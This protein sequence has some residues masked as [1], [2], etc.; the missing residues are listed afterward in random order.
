MNAIHAV[1]RLP[2]VL[3]VIAPACTRGDDDAE[4][5]A[6]STGESDAGA[7][8][9]AGGGGFDEAAV[10]ARALAYR[11]D[12]TQVSDEPRA[13]QHGLADTVQVWASPEALMA[14]R[15]LDPAG[16]DA[17]AWSPAAMLLKEHLD[18]GGVVSGYTVMAQGD[19]DSSSDGWWWGRLDADGTV[20]ETGQVGFCI[21]CHTTV[22]ARG[23]A[24]G[25]PLDNR[26]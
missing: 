9:G 16:T 17:V 21:G 13:S 4:P 12:F 15:A 3:A 11:D 18:A 10:I 23:W 1:R 2:L 26:R 6:S 24:Y 20:H 19:P 25:V 8:S 22:A 7:S 14:Y 5:G